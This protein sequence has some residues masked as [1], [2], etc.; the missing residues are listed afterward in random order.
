MLTVCATSV[1]E[2]R[3]WHRLLSLLNGY[4]GVPMNPRFRPVILVVSTLLLMGPYLG[5][6]TYYSQRFPSNHWPLW[7]T[8]TILIWFVAN[9]LVLMLVT[10]LTRRMFPIQI[11]DAEKAH[12]VGQNAVRYA[13][14]LVIFWVG[15]FLY[16][17]I[18]TM[19]GK[20]PIERAVPAGLFLLLFLG[21]FGWRIYRAKRGIS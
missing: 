1:A 8:N 4:T 20:V 11:T 13:T 18:Q 6:V 5:F 12:V 21:F 15:L 7:F 19:R 10:R 16:G 17:L 14:R 2:I 3:Q 9:F